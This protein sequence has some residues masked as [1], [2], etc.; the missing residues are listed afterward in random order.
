MNLFPGS[1]LWTYLP[2]SLTGSRSW[3]GWK[4]QLALVEILETLHVQADQWPEQSVERR[5]SKET[6]TGVGR[7]AREGRLVRW[8]IY[9]PVAMADVEKRVGTILL[10]RRVCVL[11]LRG[12]SI[13]CKQ[14][15]LIW[16]GRHRYRKKRAMHPQTQLEETPL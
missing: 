9:G 3:G 2:Q 12:L 4:A 6:G 13:V 15:L 1:M 16:S 5:R 7:R 10:K 8:T 14:A 11:G